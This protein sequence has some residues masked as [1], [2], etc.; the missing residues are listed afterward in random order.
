MFSSGRCGRSRPSCRPHGAHRHRRTTCRR[1]QNTFVDVVENPVAHPDELRMASRIG[2]FL[3]RTG[4]SR[5]IEPL[6]RCARG[7]PPKS[8]RST[9]ITN[10]AEAVQRGLRRALC[11]GLNVSLGC[12]CEGWIG[13]LALT[14]MPIHTQAVAESPASQEIRRWPGLV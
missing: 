2:R 1:A 12:R 11:L 3:S 8:H 7:T 10:T 5:G 4:D 14:L 9:G 13:L 6:H